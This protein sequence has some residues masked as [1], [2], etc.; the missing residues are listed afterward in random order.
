MATFE[1][2]EDGTYRVEGEITQEDID[3]IN[4]FKIRTNL[5]LQNT[6]GQSSEIIKQIKTDNVYFSILGGLDYYEKNKYDTTDYR[7]RTQSNAKGLTKILQYFER[8]EAGMNANWTD[9]QKCMYAY[10]ALA[11]DTD[12]VKDLNQDILSQ[13]VTERG[14][15]GVLYNQL[16]C[17]GMAKTFKEM[18]DRIGIKCYYQNQRSVHAFNV[19]ELD[20]KL[21][22]VDVTWDCTKNPEEKCSFRNF[23]RDPKFYEKYGHQIAGDSQEIVFDLTTFTDQEIQENYAVIASAINERKR[24]VHPFRNFDRD[25]KRKFLPVNTFMEKLEDERSAFVKLRLL[26]QFGTIPQEITEFVSATSQRYGF[27]N[28]YMGSNHGYTSI[29]KILEGIQRKTNINGAILMKEGQAIVKT[30]ENGQITEKSFTKEQKE[31]MT[32]MLYEDIKNYYTQY[33]QNEAPQIDDLIETYSMIQNMPSEMAIKTA[34]LKT[35]LYTKINLF[36][37]GDRFFEQLGIPKEDIEITCQK[38]RECLESTREFTDKTKPQHEYDLD[39]LYA[40]IQ[41]DVIDTLVAG[42]EYTEDNLA[43][44]IEDVKT[45]WQDA[46]FSDEEFKKILNEILSKTMSNEDIS[47]ST[48][49]VGIGLEE[50]NA[51]I[52]EIRRTQTKDNQKEIKNK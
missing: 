19:V 31:E 37:N 13:G 11:V 8:I 17:A 47:R 24:I 52:N 38:A 28:D 36:A 16:T 27:I 40:I 23:G 2:I 29:S 42:Q 30:R 41:N 49:D 7:E 15:N 18:M 25:R 26:S 48:I 46:E 35:Q 9:T 51:V 34:T 6:K 39:L 21:R 12:Y 20:G 10:N 44:L 43:K 1:L 32:L 33:F 50:T 45:N 4:S 22:G 14:L 5:V 3:R